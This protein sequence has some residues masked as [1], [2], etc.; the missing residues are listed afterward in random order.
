MPSIRDDEPDDCVLD[1]APDPDCA[2][3]EDEGVEE[4]EELVVVEEEE[5]GEE[6]VSSGVAATG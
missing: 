3:R 6:G 5:E 2:E 1:V 4:E